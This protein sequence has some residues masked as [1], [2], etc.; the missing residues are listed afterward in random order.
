MRLTPPP[1]P[2]P[3]PLV[4]LNF[5]SRSEIQEYTIKHHNDV[6]VGK[7]FAISRTMT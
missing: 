1:P 5:F 2:P 3:P 7:Q 6:I 4:S